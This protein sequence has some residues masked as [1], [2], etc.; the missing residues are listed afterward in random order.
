MHAAT[1]TDRDAGTPLEIANRR[2]RDR[3]EFGCDTQRCFRCDREWMDITIR[4]VR[5]G[6]TGYVWAL[7]V[8]C[9]N[10]LSPTDRLLYFRAKH[11][12]DVRAA[13]TAAIREVIESRWPAIEQAVIAPPA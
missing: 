12:E 8:D 9:W 7:C 3:A 10:T 2:E 6:D 11:V 13:K 5:A 1:V 4:M